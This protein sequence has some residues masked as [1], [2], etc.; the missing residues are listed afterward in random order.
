MADSTV[1]RT[2][3]RRRNSLP[4]REAIERSSYTV[5]IYSLLKALRVGE[6]RLTFP[7]RGTVTGPEDVVMVVTG[8]RRLSDFNSKEI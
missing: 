8:D 3:R 2:G 1:R 4:V 6:F 7:G 5:R